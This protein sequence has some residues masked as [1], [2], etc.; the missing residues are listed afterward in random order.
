MKTQFFL[1]EGLRSQLRQ[2]AQA[3]FPRECCGLIEGVRLEGRSEALAL[4][5]TINPRPEPDRFEI[6]PAAH[7]ALLRALRGTGREVIGCYHSHPGGA[8]EPSAQDRENGGAPDF[9]WLIAGLADGTSEP[10][11][12]AFAGE[13]FEPVGLLSAL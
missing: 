12:G 5:P 10:V 2:E 13:G 3:A 8:P 9:V 6:D 1:S 4:H 11:L 7:I